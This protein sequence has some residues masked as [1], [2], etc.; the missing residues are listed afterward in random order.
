MALRPQARASA[1]PHGGKGKRALSPAMSLFGN[2]AM[3][4]VAA[5]ICFGLMRGFRGVIANASEPSG[6]ML[7]TSRPVQAGEAISTVNA[8]WRPSRA[9]SRPV[10]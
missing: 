1:Q 4:I 10:S 7:V 2:I 9:G 3:F 6:Y 5:V 8:Q